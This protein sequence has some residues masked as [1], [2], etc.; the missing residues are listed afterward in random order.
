[1]TKDSKKVKVKEPLSLVWVSESRRAFTS[2]DKKVRRAILERA[3]KIDNFGY[4]LGEELGSKFSSLDKNLKREILRKTIIKNNN[5]NYVRFGFTHALA[6]TIGKDFGNLDSSIQKEILGNISIN[7]DNPFDY[8][9]ATGIGENFSTLDNNLKKE[10]FKIVEKN[11]NSD[12]ADGIGFGLSATF[13][14]LG[15]DFQEKL[16]KIVEHDD[17]QFSRSLVMHF[18]YNFSSMDKD[19]Q[20]IILNKVEQKVWP[21]G[22]SNALG[23][24]FGDKFYYSHNDPLQYEFRRLSKINRSFARGFR[25]ATRDQTYEAT[26]AMLLYSSLLRLYSQQLY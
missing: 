7:D 6:E 13:S 3:E 4:S 25:D 17:N 14:S 1:M 11:Y 26:K 20:K 21:S 23:Y 2:L 19:L 16:F 9:L 18:G 24:A 22:Y 8:I 15:K 12:F 5:N 10:V